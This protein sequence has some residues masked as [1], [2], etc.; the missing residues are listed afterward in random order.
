MFAAALAAALLAGGGAAQFS[1]QA[2]DSLYL[3]DWGKRVG[4]FTFT[5]QN[6]RTVRSDDLLGK[7]W[8]ANFFFTTCQQGICAKTNQS[9]AQLQRDLS[10]LPDV[11]LVGFSVDPEADTPAVLHQFAQDWGADPQRWL[12]LTGDKAAMYAVIREQFYEGVEHQP[13]K[14]PGYQVDHTNHLMVIDRNGQIRGFVDGTKP[15][16]VERLEKRVRQLVGVGSPFPAVNATLNGTSLVLLVAAY[17]A[18][19]RRWVRTHEVLMLSAL[20]VST[21]FL[22]SYSYYH[23][24]IRRG[25]STH[26]GGEGWVEPLY[27]GVLISHIILA[28]VIIPL[29][30]VTAALGLTGRL[31]RHI[32]LARWT[33]PLWLYVCITGVVIYW[34]LYHLYPP[35]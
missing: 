22:V 18:I 1:S 16:E 35:A 21:T 32:R 29:A 5:D 8:V 33:F 11:M 30:L 24:V 7:V 20:V 9:M 27:Y 17:L 23:I 15:E 14:E 26:F 10:N 25:E 3:D 2:S 31:S 6:G 12:F 34:M 19:R 13:G 4:P 28:V